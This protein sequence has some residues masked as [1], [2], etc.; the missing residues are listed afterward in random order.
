V[1]AILDEA[2][3]LIAYSHRLEQ[4]SNELE[5]ASNEL[6]AA[7]ARLLEFDHM[8]DDFISSVTHELRTPLTSIRAFSEILR[9]HPDLA[10][11]QRREYLDIV[12]KESERL[13]RLINDVLDLAKLESGSANWHA[14]ALEPGAVIMDAI[15]ATSE[16]MKS[17]HIRLELDIGP[18]LPQVCADRDRL[19]QVMLNLLSNAIKFC[20]P[21]NGRIEI[22]VKQH[23]HAGQLQIE[24]H[25]NGAGVRQ[26]DQ[27]LI[28]QKFRQ[29]GDSAIG[30][31]QGT[32]LGLPISREI[33]SHFGGQLW[34]ESN[35][36]HG[37]RFAFTLPLATPQ[38]T[39]T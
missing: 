19:M 14:V 22:K 35:P 28:F 25:D 36:G 7:N 23:E 8:K 6:K 15:D 17:K 30:K 13:T 2:S 3:Q 16:L 4:K 11:A 32:G 1:M 24:V 9:D 34:V 33:I 12:I 26:Q 5:L 10:P 37:A 29:G 31:P 21:D 27:E 38:E 18:D 20:Q 39:S